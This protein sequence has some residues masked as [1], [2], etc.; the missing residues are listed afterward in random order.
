MLTRPSVEPDNKI[1]D[2]V[3]WN[4]TLDHSTSVSPYFGA[5]TNLR[6]IVTVTLNI[7]DDGLSQGPSIP[8]KISNHVIQRIGPAYHIKTDA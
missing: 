2:R 7:L 6:D 5:S 4:C 8:I 1:W 3:G